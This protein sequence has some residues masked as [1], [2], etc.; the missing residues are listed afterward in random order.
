MHDG[1][2]NGDVLRAE[3]DGTADR[4]RSITD[5]ELEEWL[6]EKEGAAMERAEWA[7]ENPID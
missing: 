2:T 7:A 6:A 1:I 3:L 4:G 5:E